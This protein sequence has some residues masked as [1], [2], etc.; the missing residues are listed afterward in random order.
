MSKLTTKQL[1]PKQLEQ[2][3]KLEQVFHIIVCFDSYS[4]NY[5]N[6]S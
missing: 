2:K 6:W 5:R 3:V 4:L 1:L